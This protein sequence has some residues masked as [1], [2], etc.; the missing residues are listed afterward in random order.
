MKRLIAALLLLLCS[1]PAFAQVPEVHPS[2]LVPHWG[3]I[4]KGPCGVGAGDNCGSNPPTWHITPDQCGTLFSTSNARNADG[5]NSINGVRFTLPTVAEFAAAGYSGTG[6]AASSGFTNRSGQCVL[7]FVMG[8]PGP[9]NF[10]RIGIEGEAGSDKVTFFGTGAYDMNW[11]DLVY[12]FPAPGAMT[13]VWNGTSW[14]MLG[15]SPA[16][17]ERAFLGQLFSHGQGRL[18]R[19]TADPSWWTAGTRVGAL[20]YCPLSGRGT[21]GASSGGYM[22]A[23]MP[24]NCTFLD[25]NLANGTDWISMRYLGSNNVSAI[26]AGASYGAGTAPNGVTYGAGNYVVLITPTL[27]SFA[28]GNTVEVHNLRPELGTVTDGKWIGKKLVAGVDPGCPVASNCV[29][30]HQSIDQGN[31]IDAQVA[32]GPPSSFV[33]GDSISVTTTAMSYP[34]LAATG[35]GSARF[36]NPV[37]GVDVISATRNTIVGVAR[38]TAAN[39]YEDSNTV[40]G[41]ASA[42]NPMDKRCQTTYSTDRTTTSTTYATP[43]TEITCD[44][45]YFSGVN[46]QALDLGDRGQAVKWTLNA[47]V[48]NN[49]ASDGCQVTAV[50]NPPAAWSAVTTY[51][52]NERASSGGLVYRSIQAANLNNAVS[53]PAWWVLVVSPSA[54]FTNPAGE[55]GNKYALTVSGAA[56]SL[57]D[58]LVDGLN[59]ITVQAKVLTGGTCTLYSDGTSLITTIP[60]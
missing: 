53:D 32:V 11:G 29:E 6:A 15:S 52:L 30:L 23:V 59:T 50:V 34:A 7:S 31:G 46:K 51:G 49:T 2:T 3:Y 26:A 19:V 40:R 55:S 56:D 48:S 20:A 43:N 13:I 35:T 4:R 38:R 10:L 58:G 36:T 5:S 28:S 22:L 60:Q 17:A 12:P 47:T 54:A 24:A 25:N 44:F 33:A 14:L 42:F 9:Q 27:V 16:I 57:S 45:A 39:G 21:V 8:A 1:V 18:F 41:V 37:N